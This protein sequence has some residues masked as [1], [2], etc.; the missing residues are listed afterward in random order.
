MDTELPILPAGLQQ[1]GLNPELI[2]AVQ[3]VARLAG[4]ELLDCY[5]GQAYTTNMKS[6]QT[7]VTSADLHAHDVIHKELARL[8]P[9]IPIL[10]EESEGIEWSTRQ[11]WNPYWLVD[12]LDGTQEFVARSGDFATMLALIHNNH[13]VF[14]VVYAPVSDTLYWAAEGMGAWKISQDE[15]RQIQVHHHEEL[16]SH[17]IVATSRRQPFE[18]IRRRLRGISL[19]FLPFGSAALKACLVAEGAA[20]C[21]LRIGPTGEWDTGASQVIL[22]EAGG[23]LLDLGLRPL[24]FNRRESLIN[25][26]FICIGDEKL[27]WADMLKI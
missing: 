18:L 3:A 10:S 11:Q 23:E 22:Q 2:R 20:D 5:K 1:A 26:N 17:L 7:L 8:T 9:D 13:P 27:P 19:D 15:E 12:P 4:K 25:P 6:D 14:G 21:Y 16:P 24:S